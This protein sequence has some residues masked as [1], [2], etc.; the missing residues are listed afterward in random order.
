[1]KFERVK[2]GSLPPKFSD[3]TFEA[4]PDDKYVSMTSHLSKT[5]EFSDLYL[6]HELCMQILS[7]NDNLNIDCW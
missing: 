2:S 7:C 6:F 5:V 3:V 4:G 1:M